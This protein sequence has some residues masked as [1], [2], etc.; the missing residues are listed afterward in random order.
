L[1]YLLL[2]SSSNGSTTAD[3]LYALAGCLNESDLTSCDETKLGLFIS[4][5]AARQAKNFCDGTKEWRFG[6]DDYPFQMGDFQIPCLILGCV[7]R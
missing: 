6:S 1:G 7:T 4:E 2:Q 5:F 3:A